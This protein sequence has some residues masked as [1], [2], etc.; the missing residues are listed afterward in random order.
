MTSRALWVAASKQSFQLEP[1]Y[2]GQ[3]FV[4]AARAIVPR[5]RYQVLAGIE[6]SPSSIRCDGSG[7]RV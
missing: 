4:Y 1:F 3:T 6:N 5:R 2:A 7:E